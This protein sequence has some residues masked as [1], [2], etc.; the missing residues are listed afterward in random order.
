[1]IYQT[2]VRVLPIAEKQN[3]KSAFL[4]VTL[5][6]IFIFFAG[7]PGSLRAQI[8]G[9]PP[10]TATKSGV[11][12]PHSPDPVMNYK[13]KN[14]KATDGLESYQLRPR[15][16]TASN[17]ASFNTT[18]FKKNNVITV[19][20][21]G[22]I[23]FD[24]GQENAG[25]LE[26]DSADLTD[27]ITMSISEYN[28]PPIY[29]STYPPKTLPPKKHGNTYR[30]ELN[31]ELYEGVRFGWIHV[32]SFSK[33]W[34]ITNLRLICQVRPTNYNGSFSCSD[35][36]LTR[37]WYTGA[38]TVKLN[39]LKDYLG[40]ILMYRGD[41]FSWTGDAHP[42][43]AASMVA[44]GNY[45][46]IK[47]NIAYTSTQSNGIRSYALYWVLSLIDY[48]KYTGDTATL[49]NYID[50]ACAKLDDA[51]KVYGTNPNLEY[52]GWDERLGAGFEHPNIPEPQN[53]Y[54]MLSIRAWKEFSVAMGMCGRTDLRDK[55]NNYATEK[56]GALRNS[57]MWYRDFGLHAGADAITTGLL[58]TGEKD[59]IY[60]KSFT[61]RVN[62]ISYSPFNQYFVI[63]AFALMNKYDDALGSVRDLWGGQVKYGGTSFF[64]DYRPSWNALVGKNGPVPN[65]Q[66]GFTSLCHP[67][68]AGVT[69]WL[70]EEVL[71]IKPTA[72]GFATFDIIPHLGRTLTNVSGKTPTLKG[73]INA[74][75]NISTG[76]CSV[77]SP[78]GTIGR[79]GIPKAGK[80]ITSVKINGVL[81]WD[82]SFHSV[83]GF[84]GA[85]EDAE[86]I[87]FTRMLP[88]NYKIIAKYSGTTPKYTEPVA[89]YAASYIGIDTTT[90]G[91]W[92]GVYGKDGFALC[93]YNDNGKDKTS[94]PSYVSS[95]NYY[96][97]KGNNLPRNTVWASNTNDRRAPAPDAA[98]SFPRAAACLYA[99][100]ADQIG[101]TFT[102]TITIKGTHD[103]KV[104]LYFVDWDKKGRKIAVEMFDA[105]TSNLVAPVKIV[106]NCVGGAYVTY[107][108]NKSVKFRINVVRGDNPVL[109]GIFFDP[110]STKN[111]K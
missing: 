92:G 98:N 62:R 23:R 57:G 10:V 80:A 38:Y 86:F 61:D 27:S 33:T 37:I 95:I 89:S 48:Y 7:C 97:V 93:N 2:H 71:G 43:Q 52:Y 91:N 19:N 21:T 102:S 72:P 83:H 90:S 73:N 28:Q 36:L 11:L 24:F 29:S 42:A 55:Y 60:E 4:T 107:S 108:Y 49:K 13:W 35:T 58:N 88:G 101:Y 25:W 3:R 44:F 65:N 53:S 99:M 17:A 50:N 26:F 100:D 51:Y 81:A 12:N 6:L 78:A 32:R 15:S 66:C 20:G 105:E 59:A 96:K 63:Q 34:H 39:L 106:E 75:F 30:L 68:G 103:Y 76:M 31:T 104:S 56:I 84:S 14:P 94:L 8:T 47:K 109:S 5:I 18:N 70:S 40:A 110:T 54:K 82:G 111:V 77:S 85:S 67:W 9:Y 45:D 87:Y 46:F 74:S 79:I 64:E 16:W 69:K 41:R 1:M 22:D